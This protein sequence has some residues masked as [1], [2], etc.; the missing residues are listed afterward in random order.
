LRGATFE[1]PVQKADVPPRRQLLEESAGLIDGDRN[2]NYGSPVANFTN[3]AKL[4]NAR[5]EHMFKEGMEFTPADVATIQILTKISRMVTSPG[6][7]DHWLDIAGYAG[8]GWE[9]IEEG[10]REA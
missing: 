2:K 7:K 8:C 3:T 10:A 5:F 9:C 4:L 1:P 6:K